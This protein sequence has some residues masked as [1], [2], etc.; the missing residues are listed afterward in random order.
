[1]I[2]NDERT[3][4]AVAVVAPDARR[5]HLD[6]FSTDGVRGVTSIK[7]YGEPG[8]GAGDYGWIPAVAVYFNDEED[9]RVRMILSPGMILI[10]DEVAS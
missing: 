1:M 2:I 5:Q 7:A 6:L 4:L 9:P 8:A 10:Y 3:I